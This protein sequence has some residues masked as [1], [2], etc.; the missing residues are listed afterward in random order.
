[1]AEPLQSPLITSDSTPRLEST[2]MRA[3]HYILHNDIKEDDFMLDPSENNKLEH[4]E[5]N[6]ENPINLDIHFEHNNLKTEEYGLD[7]YRIH[8]SRVP[9]FN[10]SRERKGSEDLFCSEID[11]KQFFGNNE[12]AGGIELIDKNDRDKKFIIIRDE[13]ID[14]ENIPD[15]STIAKTLSK[16]IIDDFQED[17]F[18]SHECLVTRPQLDIKVE[19]D[20]VQ[21]DSSILQESLSKPKKKRKISNVR[22]ILLESEDKEDKEHYSR[23]PKTQKLKSKAK[24]PFEALEQTTHSI[25]KKKVKKKDSLSNITKKS[26]K[27]NKDK[28][29]EKSASKM[30]LEQSTDTNLLEGSITPCDTKAEDISSTQS[31]SG[32]EIVNPSPQ[33]NKLS[34]FF[35]GMALPP[36]VEEL[37]SKSKIFN[38]MQYPFV[39]KI[40]PLTVEERQAKVAKYLQK[41]KDRTWN[42]RINYDC[43]KRVADSRLRFKG[44]FVTKSQIV[45]ILEE[46]G[47]ETNNINKMTDDEIKSLLEKH[48]GGDIV[49][50]KSKNENKLRNGEKVRKQST[51]TLSRKARSSKTN[52]EENTD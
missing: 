46:E 5:T 26:P 31:R 20:S 12:K 21:N 16:E 17:E 48:F 30:N 7:C 3:G 15:F 9:S 40:G 32:T 33:R 35:Y 10:L 41:R 43:R 1:M 39:K 25:T 11:F 18:E 29:N 24:R 38:T 6:E 14:N 42:K 52:S 51:S 19:E 45:S 2:N 47:L 49:N 23:T 27:N 37:I 22:G 13:D 36:E 28:A 8:R 44:R 34:N 50:K 4:H